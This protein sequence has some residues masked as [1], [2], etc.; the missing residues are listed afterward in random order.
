MNKTYIPTIITAVLLFVLHKIAM[1]NHW[2]VR[3][4]GF[5]IFMHIFGGVVL[6]LAIHWII[7]TFLP[8]WNSTFWKIIV[9]TFIAGVLWEL[10]EA[11][12][13]IANAPIG[14]GLYFLDTAKDLVNDTL[15]AIIAAFFLKK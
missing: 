13:D 8:R 9:L 4:T 2:Y 3:F 12:N 10:F 14:S 6:A 1:M 11:A 7:C 5:D 15:G